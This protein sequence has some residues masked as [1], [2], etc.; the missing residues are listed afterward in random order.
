MKGKVKTHWDASLHHETLICAVIML[1]HRVVMIH[2]H[3]NGVIHDKS[4]DIMTS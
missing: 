4:Y 1:C 2:L 3:G